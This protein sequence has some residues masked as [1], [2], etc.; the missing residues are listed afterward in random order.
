MQRL[1]LI[2]SLIISF[3]LSNDFNNSC[4]ECHKGIEEIRDHKSGMMK[5]IFK[6]A[7]EAAY[8]Y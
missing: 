3:L 7:D 2:L 8:I 5:A 4:I 1:I 6:M